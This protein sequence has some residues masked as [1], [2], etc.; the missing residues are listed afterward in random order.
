MIEDKQKKLKNKKEKIEKIINM[1]EKPRIQKEEL[2]TIDK[3]DNK[4]KIQKTKL[5]RIA[6]E[7][8]GFDKLIEG[9]FERDSIILMVGAAGSGKTF[10]AMQVLL[11][12]LKKGETCLY[13]SFE[14][15]RDV[16]F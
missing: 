15:K 7:I 12:A 14:E 1:E 3:V 11:A 8:K 2:R 4:N 13:I 6:T 5:R 16:F 10:F 9:G